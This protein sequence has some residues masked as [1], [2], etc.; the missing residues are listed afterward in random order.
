MRCVNINERLL[1]S[2]EGRYS[3]E[4]V[5]RLVGQWIRNDFVVKKKFCTKQFYQCDAMQTG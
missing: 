2:D 1:A 4:L 5:V 3:R